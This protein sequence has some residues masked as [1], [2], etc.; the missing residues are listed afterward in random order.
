MKP[1]VGLSIVAVALMLA[2]AGMHFADVPTALAFALIAT[3]VAITVIALNYHR[4]H[5]PSH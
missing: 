2:G 4:Q 3:G 5:G 1:N